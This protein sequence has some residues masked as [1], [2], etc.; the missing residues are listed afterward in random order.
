MFLRNISAC[1]SGARALSHCSNVMRKPAFQVCDQG[2]LKPVCLAIEASKRLR[3]SDIAT[4]YIIPSRQRKIKLLIRLRRLICVF[5]RIQAY[6]N[7]FPIGVWGRVWN[8]IVSVPDHC[9]FIY[10]RWII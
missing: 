5:V 8:S 10:F 9:L 4:V 2:R 7:P 3:I 1:L 6:S